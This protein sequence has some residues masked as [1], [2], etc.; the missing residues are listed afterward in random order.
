MILKIIYD[1]WIA[2]HDEKNLS[3]NACGGSGQNL[4]DFFRFI[5][6]AFND[7]GD[8]ACINLDSVAN[9]TDSLESPVYYFLAKILR[10]NNFILQI[11]P[12]YINFKDPSEVAKMF[13][14]ITNISDRNSNSGPTYLCIYG[15]GNSEVLNINEQSRYTFTND[16]F[17]ILKNPPADISTSKN[18]KLVAFRV[19]FGSENQSLFKSVALNQQE[20]R[21]TAEY[22]AALAELIDKRG[23]TQRSYKGTDLYSMYRTRSYTCN[24]ESL[25]CMNIQ[26]MMYFQLDNV[27]FF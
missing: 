12:S 7:I 14:P 18:T 8:I 10:D 1:S 19:S 4:F 5:D 23:G 22:H 11:L 20:H 17:D 16:G 26:P 21:K 9:L 15:N 13:K 24:V 6:R 27:P 2:G 25:G 3:Y